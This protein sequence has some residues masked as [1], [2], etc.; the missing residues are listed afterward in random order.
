AEDAII[1]YTSDHGEMLYSH[2]LTAKGPAMYNEITNIPFIVKGFGKNQ[3]DSHP[4]SHIN[5]TPTVLELFDI[6]QPKVLEGVSILN[7]LKTGERTNPY[8]SEFGR[9]EVDQTDLE[10]ISRCVQSLTAVTSWSSI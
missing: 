1:I 2:S 6:P 3:V 10:V 9:Y 5:I 7:E 8:F 4:V